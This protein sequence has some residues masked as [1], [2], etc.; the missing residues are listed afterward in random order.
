MK[1]IFIKKLSILS[2]LFLALMNTSC[3]DVLSDSI[4]NY[5][6]ELKLSAS[7]QEVVLDERKPNENL[8][9]KW[10]TGTNKGTG[11]AISYVLQIDKEGNNF[12]TPL[13]Y[14]MGKNVFT[15]SLNW[16]T[17]N[18]I[19]L[20]TFGVQPGATQKIEARIIATVS[21]QN[22][23]KQISK[24]VVNITTFVPVSSQLYMVG[25]ATSVGWNVSSAV[26]MTLSTSQPGTFVYQGPLNSG[27]FKLPVNRDGCWCQDFYTKSATDDTKMVH[28]IGGSGQDLQWQISR[29]GQYKVTADLLN[30]TIKIET[31]VG[32]PFTQIYIV[33]DASPSGWDV[34]NPKAF[35]QSQTNPFIFTYEANLTSGSFKIL[36]G[37][38]GNWCG[39]WYRPLTDGQALSATT[40]DQNSGCSVDNKWNVTSGDVGRYKIELNTANNT[41][42]IKK[43]NLYIIGDGG[44]NGWNIGT[45]TPMTY[46]NGNYTYNGPL[47]AGEFKISKFKGDWCDG[48]WINAATS[49]QN[50][51]NGSYIGTHACD[52]PDNKWKLQSGDAGNYQISIN[53][54]SQSMTIVRQ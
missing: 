51:L 1:N 7:N 31:I 48:D 3:E 28:N 36:A 6:D 14:Q 41:I 37:A 43:V 40:V 21:N 39:E 49:N 33:G 18:S 38:K 15:Y 11:A 4:Q 10:T 13:D 26:P 16:A 25:S 34:D 54:D 22:V 30:L 9:F 19:L 47:N 32:P 23:E 45:P 46:S 53:L 12:A 8:T 2:V 50:I 35:T 27:S 24:V 52:G 44:P 17:L 42:S 5:N 20:N 29:A